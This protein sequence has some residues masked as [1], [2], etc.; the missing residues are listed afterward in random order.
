MWCAEIRTL[1]QSGWEKEK[2]WKE[3]SESRRGTVLTQIHDRWPA[4]PVCAPNIDY[5]FLWKAAYISSLVCQQDPSPRMYNVCRCDRHVK[6]CCGIPQHPLW[7]TQWKSFCVIWNVVDQ[8]WSLLV[9]N[10][11]AD[12]WQP[13]PSISSFILIRVQRSCYSAGVLMAKGMG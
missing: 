7:R 3:N 2:D 5:F 12:C 1:R 13:V 4:H 6:K 9:G 11:F 8:F 10:G